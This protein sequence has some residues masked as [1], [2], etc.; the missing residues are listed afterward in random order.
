MKRGE[1][2]FTII[3]VLVAAFIVVIGSLA[4]FMTFVAA[5]HGIQNSKQAQVGVNVAQRELEKV[6][7]KGLSPTGYAEIGLTALP[8]F[9][10]GANLPESRI[11]GNEFDVDRET[12]TNRQR[13]LPMLTGSLAPVQRNVGTVEGT[14]VTVHR[15][16]VCEAGVTVQECPA[17]RVIID[18]TPEGAKDEPARSRSY[19]ELQSTVIRPTGVPE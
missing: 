7:A 1:E 15:F 18:V 17:K 19:F 8:V 12:G 9:R 4:V 16:V 10:T 6:R 5:I 2:G 13:L 11:V 3:E 14:K